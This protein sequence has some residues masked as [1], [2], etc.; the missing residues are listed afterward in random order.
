MQNLCLAEIVK[1]ALLH[2]G[3]NPALIQ[4][5]DSHATVQIDLTDGPA[6]Y[7]GKLD[8]H[9]VIWSDLCDF[10]ESIV[11]HFAESLL[12]EVMAGFPYGRNAQLVLR[13]SEG[14]LQI[15]CD[16]IEECL[17]D[18]GMMAEAIDA[19]FERQKRILEIIRQ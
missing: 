18:V 7:I 12:L 5:L 4:Q 13:E 15:Y 3:C 19:F 11:Q 16:V 8:E 6:L 2:C 10:H 14:S 9:V 17:S 1:D